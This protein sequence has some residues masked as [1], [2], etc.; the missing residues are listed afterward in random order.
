MRQEF[1]RQDQ[2]QPPPPPQRQQPTPQQQPRRQTRSGQVQPDSRRA[3][4]KSPARRTR[5]KRSFFDPKLIL[6]SKLRPR[7]GLK[8]PGRF[9]F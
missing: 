9:A 3:A 2:Q 5:N 8:K 1:R 4:S 6:D 7:E